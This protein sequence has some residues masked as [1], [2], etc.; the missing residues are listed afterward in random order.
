MKNYRI[1][2]ETFDGCTTI[3]YEKS[4]AKKAT[5][6]ICNRVYSQLCGLNVKRI[7]VELSV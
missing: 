3:W 6:I 7:E 5:D 2:V 4:R 1:K